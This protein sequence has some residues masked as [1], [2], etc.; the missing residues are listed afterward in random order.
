MA[1]ENLADWSPYGEELQEGAPQTTV[2]EPPNTGDAKERA[3]LTERPEEKGERGNLN[4]GRSGMTREARVRTTATDGEPEIDAAGNVI[5]PQPEGELDAEGN[6][7]PPDGGQH[8]PPVFDAKSLVAALQEAGV[9]VPSQQPQTDDRLKMTPEQFSKK[10]NVYTPTAETLTKLAAGGDSALA[11]IDEIAQGA[12]LQ[13]VTMMQEY[14]NEKVN[15]VLGQLKPFQEAQGRAQEEGYKARF[16][17]KHADLKPFDKLLQMHV[18]DAKNRNLKFKDEAAMFDYFNKSARATLQSL[19]I[20]PQAVVA[21][22]P[23]QVQPTTVRRRIATVTTVGSPTGEQDGRPIQ[24]Q[25]R[26]SKIAKQL[27]G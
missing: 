26:G 21:R 24:S 25:G 7:I 11:A 15:A 2:A 20:V 23:T 1:N 22:G 19:K 16:Y 9:V 6:L 8:Q 18:A 5:E 14:V 17:A 13:T 3:A 4:R 27:W 10:Y 12:S